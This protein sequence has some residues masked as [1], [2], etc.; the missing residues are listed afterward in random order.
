[1]NRLP[2]WV[3]KLIDPELTSFFTFQDVGILVKTAA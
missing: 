1:M 3:V 2:R